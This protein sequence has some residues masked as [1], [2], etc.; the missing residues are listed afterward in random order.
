MTSQALDNSDASEVQEP[1]G[2][3]LGLAKTE[4]A[5]LGAQEKARLLLELW[6]LQQAGAQEEEVLREAEEA[7][8]SLA[9]TVEELRRVVLH[10]EAELH[11]RREEERSR[12][13]H[14]LSDG[15]AETPGEGG[16][17]LPPDLARTLAEQKAGLEA[18][19]A[20]HHALSMLMEQASHEDARFEDWADEVGDSG[21]SLRMQR[22]LRE[23]EDLERE[24]DRL[25]RSESRLRKEHKNWAEQMHEEV[26]EVEAQAQDDRY[27]LREQLAVLSAEGEVL[28][29]EI[30]GAHCGM[31]QVLQRLRQEESMLQNEAHDSHLLEESRSTMRQSQIQELKAIARS[32]REENE[33][34]TLWPPS[35]SSKGSRLLTPRSMCQD[36]DPMGSR[37]SSSSR[38]KR[39]NRSLLDE[40]QSPSPR[41]SL[42]SPRPGSA[43]EDGQKQSSAKLQAP[44][45]TLHLGVNMAAAC[46]T[47]QKQAQPASSSSSSS[48]VHQT[49]TVPQHCA[50]DQDR[51]TIRVDKKSGKSLGV[52]IDPDLTILSVDDEGLLPDWNRSNRENPVSA[53]HKIVEVN[54]RTEKKHMV[55]LLKSNQILNIA[56]VSQGVS[57]KREALRKGRLRST[58]ST[59]SGY[60]CT[61]AVRVS[62]DDE[63]RRS[64]ASSGDGDAVSVG[65][66]ASSRPLR[67]ISSTKLS[68]IGEDST[69][70]GDGSSR[71][72]SNA[73]DVIG[74][75]LAELD[76]TLDA[77]SQARRI[78]VFS[79]EDE[80][81]VT[82]TEANS[83]E[84]GSLEAR[85]DAL[86]KMGLDEHSPRPASNRPDSSPQS[87]AFGDVGNS[88]QPEVFRSSQIALP[89]AAHRH[90]V[91][92]QSMCSED[93]E[94]GSGHDSPSSARKRR[95]SIGWRYDTLDAGEAVA[96]IAT[97]S[98]HEGC[99]GDLE[100]AIAGSSRAPGTALGELSWAGPS[101]FE[102]IQDDSERWVLRAQ[103]PSDAIQGL[104]DFVLHTVVAVRP[105]WRDPD[106]RIF[107]V[108]L[109]NVGGERVEYSFRTATREARATWVR[110]LTE[111]VTESRRNVTSPRSRTM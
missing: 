78:S 43:R 21:T 11:D 85:Y 23:T 90:Q 97:E 99:R 88:L 18:L 107:S 76:A 87:E 12:G 67:E 63:D 65:S 36:D 49:F 30:E 92:S 69:I 3:P 41:P 98:N 15:V 68:I 111:L 60:N 64:V 19:Q 8:E 53:G 55:K 28:D 96:V 57:S 44:R 73:G 25:K 103:A 89:P 35:R 93:D 91:V 17:A 72:S 33:D 77:N 9:E 10:A 14:Q 50:S 34:P 105:E 79:L 48:K 95:T 7:Q 80:D 20:R 27:A 81:D 74:N 86:E 29:A 66:A 109:R 94:S 2:N 102:V 5:Q 31:E 110:D 101:Y 1:R 45:G 51:F 82:R 59:M 61:G 75:A 38:R 104:P 40:L 6:E 22:A 108:R 16:E 83:N 26:R 24:L 56:L 39:P 84:R 62:N 71:S 100:W 106:G 54:G 46:T 37:R 47:L 42:S 58:R 32:L 4:P 13:D 52:H 70:T